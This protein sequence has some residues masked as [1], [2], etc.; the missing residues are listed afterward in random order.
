MLVY[1]G[2]RERTEREYRDLLESAG[3]S[4]TRIID[5]FADQHHQALPLN[6]E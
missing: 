3:L 4:L 5:H 6:D 2:G 1:S